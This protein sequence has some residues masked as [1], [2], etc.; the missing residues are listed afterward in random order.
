MD[1]AYVRPSTRTRGKI[2][3]AAPWISG[4]LVIGIFFGLNFVF[5]MNILCL[6]LAIFTLSRFKYIF[7]ITLK[8][9]R[10]TISVQVQ[11]RPL[12]KRWDNFGCHF[13]ISNYVTRNFSADIIL[14]VSSKR[15]CSVTWK[16]A[17]IFIFILFTT[18]EKISFTEWGGRSFTTGFSS[19]KGLRDFRETGPWTWSR[20]MYKQHE[21]DKKR[22]YT[23]R[24]INVE[25]HLQFLA[26]FSWGW[27]ACKP[28]TENLIGSGVAFYKA[29]MLKCPSI[30][31][32]SWSTDMQAS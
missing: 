10:K 9:E 21:N 26:L 6:F 8:H 15:R 5:I 13:I 17:V 29:G 23:Q 4:L 14:F 18:Y 32:L 11:Y 22:L 25:F 31:F 24:V 7:S 20:Y 16:F 12:V 30:W 28:W 19:P 27:P 1:K 2:C 3:V